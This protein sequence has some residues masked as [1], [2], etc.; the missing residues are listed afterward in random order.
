MMQSVD[1]SSARTID[2]ALQTYHDQLAKSN[3][4][5]AQQYP[6]AALQKDSRRTIHPLLRREHLGT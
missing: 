3:P 2:G 4:V 6:L 5:A 1:I